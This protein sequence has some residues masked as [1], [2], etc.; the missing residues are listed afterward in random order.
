M[1]VVLYATDAAAQFLK[2]RGHPPM[3]GAKRT[4]RR[5]WVATRA[6]RFRDGYDHRGLLNTFFGRR[7]PHPP[8]VGDARSPT[9]ARTRFTRAASGH[10]HFGGVS[11]LRNVAGNGTEKLAVAEGRTAS[12]GASKGVGVTLRRYGRTSF[13]RVFSK[14]ADKGASGA[15]LAK[16]GDTLGRTA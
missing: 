14:M 3:G 16:T 11:P 9:R 1:S 5:Q 12:F 6:H 7:A 10:R 4:P 2:K 13:N 8:L 15:G